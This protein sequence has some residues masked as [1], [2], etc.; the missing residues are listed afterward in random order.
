MSRP[1]PMSLEAEM[2]TLARV[3]LGFHNLT[4][5]SRAEHEAILSP[6]IS[7]VIPFPSKLRR[8]KT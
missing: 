4:R 2:I 6:Q 1:H 5:G 7:P 8:P 3:L